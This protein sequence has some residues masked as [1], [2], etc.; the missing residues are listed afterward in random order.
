MIPKRREKG[1]QKAKVFWPWA[2]TAGPEVNVVFKG[3]FWLKLV[4]WEV[5]AY[6]MGQP[7]AGPQL[8]SS[9]LRPRW[10]T[11]CAWRASYGASQG[12]YGCF[13]RECPPS[14]SPCPLSPHPIAGRLSND[15][16]APSCVNCVSA[17]AVEAPPAP[18]LPGGLSVHKQTFTHVFIK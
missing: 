11:A 1:S 9:L 10:Y 6:E 8:L 17:C 3:W 13:C 4:K 14:L 7:P 15:Q 18:I 16:Q 12:S 2:D 5:W